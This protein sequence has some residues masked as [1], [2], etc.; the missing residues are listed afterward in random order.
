MLSRIFSSRVPTNW[1]LPPLYRLLTI[2]EW[3]Q[4]RKDGI[5]SGTPREREAGFIHLSCI[6][7]IDK[8]AGRVIASRLCGSSFWIL[9]VNPAVLD[10][11][12]LFMIN[13]PARGARF[14][15]LHCPLLVGQVHN[16]AR[17]DL[18]VSSD[19]I[20]GTSAASLIK[21]IDVQTC[22]AGL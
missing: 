9:T 21:P 19:L 22:T 6:D 10:S 17:V 2:N 7:Q 14:A 15:H 5:F 1:M 16:A 18:T 12:N 20:V 8:T 13:V 4:M 11:N 3:S